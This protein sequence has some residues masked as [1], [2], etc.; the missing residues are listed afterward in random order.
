MNLSDII[1]KYRG[2][3]GHL[4]LELLL[5]HSLGQTRELV[6]M[7]PEYT[8]SKKQETIIKKYAQR[9]TNGE[10]IA[11]IV[12]HKEFFGLDFI[13]NK[14]TLV[15]RPETELL[16]EL[17]LGNLQQ[18][19][20]NRQRNTLMDIGTGSGNIIISL[21]KI[22]KRCDLLVASCKFFGIDISKEALTVARK[23]A[24][25]HGVDKKIKFLHGDLL[26]NLNNSTMKQCDNL[27]VL[28]NLPYLSKEIYKS[29]PCDVKNFEPKSALYSPEKGL[30]HYKKLL[31]QIKNSPI[32]DR[33]SLTIFL[34]ISPEQKSLLQTLIKKTIPN[35]KIKFHKDLAGKWRVCEI[36]IKM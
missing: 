29:A 2:K 19:T 20:N 24:K 26:S 9:R 15:P 25:I 36:K 3:L 27:V 21:A 17:A 11:Y 28:A 22:I 13:V 10:P 7:H 14:N 4:D 35:A 18:T 8:M 30:G 23:N 6:L 33:C 1:K 32:I 34:E 5:A 31:S 12:G 16:V